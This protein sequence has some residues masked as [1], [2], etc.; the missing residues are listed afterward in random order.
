M[1]LW[2]RGRA[3]PTGEPIDLYADGDRWTTEPVANAELVS[4]GGW[5]LPGLVDSH[6]H[7]GADEPGSKFD[8]DLLREDLVR[9]VDAGVTLIRSPGLAGD[10]PYWFGEDPELPRAFHAGPWIARP[11]A[12]FDG[13]GVRAT[14]EEFP[15]VAAAQAARTGWCK[16]TGDWD[17]RS[18]PLDVDLVRAIVEAVHAV[19]GRVAMHCQ[20]QDSCYSA[21]QGGVDSIEHGQFLDPALVDQMARQGTALTPTLAVFQSHLPKAQ[22][23][24]GNPRAERFVAS[25]AEMGRTSAAAAEAGVT[26]LAGTDSRPVGTIANEI[27]TLAATGM[28][29]ET[30]LAAGSWVARAY[31]GLPG[32]EEGAP[33]DAVVY[34][35]DPR[36]DLAALDHP[37]RVVLRGRV[38]R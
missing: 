37:T 7:P 5:I 20:H 24:A 12:F 2:I 25:V 30:A 26:I 16:L 27:R 17:D 21:V 1:V 10:P 32:L 3:L 31:L 23:D 8:D 38:A 14:P 33:A 35:Q 11:G 36:V 34:D 29:A 9:H 28:P 18:E 15:V 22:A 4:D 19:G 6:T 13:W